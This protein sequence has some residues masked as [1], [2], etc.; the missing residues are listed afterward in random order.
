LE[1]FNAQV[2]Q[3]MEELVTIPGVGRKSAGVILHHI[4][5]QP[6]IIVD[7]H[8]GRVVWRLGLTSSNNPV[9][10]EQDIAGQLDREYWSEFSMTANLHGR[11]I[12]HARKPRCS[13]CFLL[14]HCPTGQELMSHG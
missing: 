7:T 3:S 2:P 4:F 11:A 5:G 9:K 12:C 10:I 13:D 6:A 8:F 14:P 1:D